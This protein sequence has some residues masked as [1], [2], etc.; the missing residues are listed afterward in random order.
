MD[1]L[2]KYFPDL[3]PLQRERF[4]ALGPLYGEW[5]GRINVISRK[6]IDQ[7]YVRHVLHSLAIAR[8]CPLN[9]GARV[10]DL[11]C[12]GGF[13]GIPLAVLFPEAR[14][15]LVDSIGKKVRVAEEVASALGLQNVRAVHGRAEQV[16]GTFD[17]VVTRAVAGMKPLIGWVWGKLAKG[18]EAG[19][20]PNGLL[21]LKGGDLAAELGETGKPHT[22]FDIS[23]FYGEAFF[24]TKKVVYFPR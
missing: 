21:A 19:A 15:T 14:F 22:V 9:P 11:G 4:G 20:L 16:A 2:L 13:P 18:T 5:N 1:E 7:L 12:G 6:D 8:V 23:D 10:M 17:F 24:E 3:T